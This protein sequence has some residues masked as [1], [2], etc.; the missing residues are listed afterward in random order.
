LVS[1]GLELGPAVVG[2]G[3]GFLSFT[4]TSSSSTGP[5]QILISNLQVTVPGDVAL[6][7][8]CGS[9]LLQ[10]SAATSRGPSSSAS[11]PSNPVCVTLGGT[12]GITFV[13]S[14]QV[15]SFSRPATSPVLTSTSITS[16][17]AGATV[18]ITLFGEAL[19]QLTF[20]GPNRVSLDFG[21]GIAV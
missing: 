9:D 4:V 15:A 3:G 6:T 11:T 13:E 7:P 16:V 17:G 19:D 5:A 20:S 14:L 12:N 1:Q 8:L 18:T 2:E 21:P 10:G